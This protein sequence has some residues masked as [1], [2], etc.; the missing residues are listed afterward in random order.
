[1]YDAKNF[2]N[3]N[4]VDINE[5]QNALRCDCIGDRTYFNQIQYEN[6]FEFKTVHIPI[7]N[8]IE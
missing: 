5:T 6:M 3:T 8:V 1:M 4:I 2:E 7:E